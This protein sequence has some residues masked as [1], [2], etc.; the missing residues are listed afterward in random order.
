MKNLEHE[1]SPTTVSS[2]TVNT[3]NNNNKSEVTFLH[4]VLS[5]CRIETDIPAIWSIV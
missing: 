3:C 2:N 5:G 4:Q 1:D